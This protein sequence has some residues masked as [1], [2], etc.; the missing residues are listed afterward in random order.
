MPFD[1][2]GESLAVQVLDR[3]RE[4]LGDPGRWCQGKEVS[5]DGK[6]MCLIGAYAWA[7]DSSGGSIGSEEARMLDAMQSS[8]PGHGRSIS[9]FNDSPSTTHSDVMSYLDS[10]RL[11]LSGMGG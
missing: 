7:V 6:R 4:R 3:M 9:T 1:G 5:D 8:I 10:V 11:R 2:S